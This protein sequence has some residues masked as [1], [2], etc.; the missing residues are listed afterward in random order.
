[1][2]PTSAGSGTFQ[3]TLVGWPAQPWSGCPV[4][5]SKRAIGNSMA[6]AS[7][8]ANSLQALLRYSRGAGTQEEHGAAYAAHGRPPV[9]AH[10]GSTLGFMACSF[11][12][13]LK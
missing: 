12:K 4:E 8:P 6:G 9:M 13:S 5:S 11:Q 10:R 2:P 3:C 7:A 1:L